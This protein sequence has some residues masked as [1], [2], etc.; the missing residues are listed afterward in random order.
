MITRTNYWDHPAV[1]QSK[2]KDLDPPALYFARHIAKTVPGKD[3]A[4]MRKGR[5][6]HA[7]LLEPESF[8]ARFPVFEGKLQTA[9][10]KAEYAQLDGVASRLDGC[11]LRDINGDGGDLADIRAMVESIRRHPRAS[12]LVSAAIPGTT[13]QPYEWG[14]P[15]TGITCKMRLDFAVDIGGECALVDVK[16]TTE[17]GTKTEAIE[18]SI[19]NF[20]L[21]LQAAH[22]TAGARVVGLDPRMYL[23]LFVEDSAPFCTRVVRLDQSAIDR[24]HSLRSARLDLLATCIAK[25]RW[26]GH[27]DDLVETVGLPRWAA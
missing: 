10:S 20:G 15:I 8:D 5:A 7:A 16:K 4:A 26:P 11:A 21:H 17:G 23:L 1:S 14:D 27:A 9:A 6:L 3:T 24:G 25:N 2:L 19:W 12:K 13:E 18:R 22:Y